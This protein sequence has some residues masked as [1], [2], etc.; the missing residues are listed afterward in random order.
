MDSSGIAS[1]TSLFTATLARPIHS[2]QFWS[3]KSTSTGMLTVPLTR[4]YCG[5]SHRRSMVRLLIVPQVVD[6]RQLSNVQV[7]QGVRRQ[8]LF[9]AFSTASSY[10]TGFPQLPQVQ[11]Q[12]HPSHSH[13]QGF[14]V[15]LP[16]PHSSTGTMSDTVT[17]LSVSCSCWRHAS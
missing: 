1:S 10:V 13:R 3:V 8:P 5:R 6:E 16:Q 7:P 2:W 9:S 12:L 11:V 15:W 4:A 17:V 14:V